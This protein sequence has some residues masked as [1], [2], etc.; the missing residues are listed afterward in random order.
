MPH[1]PYRAVGAALLLLVAS[2]AH[3]QYVWIGPG[4]T[5]QYSDRP[6]PPGTPAGKIIKAPGRPNP[7]LAALPASDVPAGAPAAATDPATNPATN[8]ATK[9]PAPTGP[10]TL[11]QQDAAYRERTKAR[12]EQERKNQQEAQRQRQDAERC[13]AARSAQAQLAS[14]TRITRYGQDGE[15]RFM[16][17]AERATQGAQVN[18]ALEGCR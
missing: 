13:D 8:P 7:A 1:S 5:R 17:D 6:P 3:A 14:G 11:A 10:P 2:A 4:G 9:P 15:K 16:S 18:R 12:E